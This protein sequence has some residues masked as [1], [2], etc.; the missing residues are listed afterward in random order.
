MWFDEGEDDGLID[1]VV[2]VREESVVQIVNYTVVVHTGDIAGAG[3]DANV[4]MR[5]HGENGDSGRQTLDD[6]TRETFDQGQRDVFNLELPELGAL[7][8]MEVGH[9]GAGGGSAWFLHRIFV[10][11]A[12]T[13]QVYIFPAFED[14]SV[15]AGTWL[16]DNDYEGV[17]KDKLQMTIDAITELD[18]DGNPKRHTEI[19]S[20]D[21]SIRVLSRLAVEHLEV[22]LQNEIQVQIETLETRKKV[23]I[24]RGD[25][26][27]NQQ[28]KEEIKELQFQIPGVCVQPKRLLVALASLQDAPVPS[29]L[30]DNAA[31]NGAPD[32]PDA[33]HDAVSIQPALGNFWDAEIFERSRKVLQG[34]GLVDVQ[35]GVIYMHG[36]L[37]RCV[38]RL[39]AG[40]NEEDVL[41]IISQ[42]LNKRVIS[43]VGNESQW[44]KLISLLSCTRAAYRR[45]DCPVLDAAECSWSIGRMLEEHGF[46]DDAVSLYR[47]AL[48]G[49]NHELGPMHPRTSTVYNNLGGLAEKRQ[50]LGLALKMY[51]KSL[52]A[53]EELLGKEHYHIATCCMNLGG[54]YKQLN[55]DMDALP[56]L[57]RALFLREKNDPRSLDTATSMHM[58]GML[59]KEMNKPESAVEI[60]VQA[61]DIRHEKLDLKEV[62]TTM[63]RQA[64]IEL[65]ANLEMYREAIPLIQEQLDVFGEDALLMNN[66]GFC[67]EQIGE[68]GRALEI[69]TAT[70]DVARQQLGERHPTV[71]VVAY[72]LG[73]LH[74]SIGNLEECLPMYELALDITGDYVDDISATYNNIGFVYLSIGL[75]NKAEL[76][77]RRAL[78]LRTEMHD[79]DMHEDTLDT[80]WHLSVLAISTLNGN[81]GKHEEALMLVR[82]IMDDREER[83]GTEDSDYLKAM[84]L[85]EILYNDMLAYA[86]R[87][88]MEALAKEAEAEEPATDIV[89][90]PD[91]AQLEHLRLIDPFV[92]FILAALG[93]K[94]KGIK[95]RDA[96]TKDDFEHTAFGEV[97]SDSPYFAEWTGD[98]PD[99]SQL[100]NSELNAFFANLYVTMEM[101]TSLLKDYLLNLAQQTTDTMRADERTP[102]NVI[103]RVRNELAKLT[104]IFDDIVLEQELVE[105]ESQIDDGSQHDGEGVLE[106]ED[107]LGADLAENAPSVATSIEDGGTA[108]IAQEHKNNVGGIG[109]LVMMAAPTSG[110][111]P[112]QAKGTGKVKEAVMQQFRDITNLY[113]KTVDSE[114]SLRLCQRAYDIAVRVLGLDHP[115]TASA[116]NN[117]GV[118]LLDK[119][120]YDVARGLLEHALKVRR[121]CL[122]EDHLDTAGLD[123]GL[124]ALSV[125]II[126]YMENL[127]MDK[128][129][130]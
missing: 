67:H 125:P 105:S 2:P 68:S 65:Y 116:G 106:V 81:P 43:K 10:T 7:E 26:E 82:T 95:D 27:T 121:I 59:L 33:C 36:L 47:Y 41:P 54:L 19:E 30:F 51:R 39:S 74:F 93:I 52:E 57:R 76:N 118:L 3:T 86:S 115:R 110:H 71:G 31:E 72:R 77:L 127:Y 24:E 21:R 56:L 84:K 17:S 35:G 123:E 14:S 49:Y 96:F 70:I 122:R 112:S 114:A 64:L 89:A 90:I 107:G 128:K 83:L 66:L 113:T 50:E 69:Y 80:L 63:T 120:E 38:R 18:I 60:L 61:L 88:E 104:T 94:G 100:P 34:A 78:H 46:D 102:E 12:A 25:F 42:V 55:Q 28:M 111:G 98:I 62:E 32:G 20:I 109:D 85:L 6:I 117:L 1:R 8:K 29:F 101:D 87:E 16:D 4:W 124:L 79:D 11:D 22:K 44:P 97:M 58:L 48:Y 9:D 15:L 92:V 108:P 119:K 40:T 99:R 23:A 5:L 126:V 91:V 37:Q 75:Y 103:D 73:V 129:L 45:D 130:Q 53:G 13:S